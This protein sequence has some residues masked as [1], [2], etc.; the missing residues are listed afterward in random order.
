VTGKVVG[1]SG[2]PFAAVS[3]ATAEGR[4]GNRP[5][6]SPS[7]FPPP[8]G[9]GNRREGAES[10]IVYAEVTSPADLTREADC[11]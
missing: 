1:R 8:Q 10:C 3:A 2:V 6:A 4:L 5:S 9:G 11:P 7:P